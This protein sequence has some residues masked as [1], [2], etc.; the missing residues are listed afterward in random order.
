[1]PADHGR[2]VDIFTCGYVDGEPD[3]LRHRPHQ[4]RRGVVRLPHGESTR[5]SGTVPDLLGDLEPAV[6]RA[7]HRRQHGLRAGQVPGRD[8]VLAALAA[9]HRPRVA[10]AG[11]REVP[12]GGRLAVAVEAV[13]VPD[14]TLRRARL[15]LGIHDGDR[16]RYVRG[17][18]RLDAEPDQ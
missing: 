16:V 18:G 12:A 17:V 8:V 5:P 9:E 7:G 4:R 2:R 6:R 13:P 11:T 1:A 15:D 3:V 10:H 14:R